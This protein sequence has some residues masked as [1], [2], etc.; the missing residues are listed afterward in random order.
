MEAEAYAHKSGRQRSDRLHPATSGSVTTRWRDRIQSARRLPLAVCVTSN[1]NA[2]EM[3]RI[4]LL[5][6]QKHHL[7]TGGS[8]NGVCFSVIAGAEAV[9]H[10]SIH[11]KAITQ[12][13]RPSLQTGLDEKCRSVSHMLASRGANQGY[14]WSGFT[15]SA[16]TL[17]RNL[18]RGHQMPPTLVMN[19]SAPV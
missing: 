7:V 6:W 15:G 9:A 13:R 4:S 11:R 19:A 3:K 18:A 14:Y 5:S 16:E 2:P 8:I 12:Q 17:G 1:W 10:R